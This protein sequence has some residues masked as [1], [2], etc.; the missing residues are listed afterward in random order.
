MFA[1]QSPIL[2][3]ASALTAQM[4]LKAAENRIRDLFK[5]GSQIWQAHAFNGCSNL[6][7]YPVPEASDE[8]DLFADLKGDFLSVAEF[9]P[10]KLAIAIHD[11]YDAGPSLEKLSQSIIVNQEFEIS[12][13]YLRGGKRSE[14]APQLMRIAENLK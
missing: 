6:C 13:Q 8:A 5:F 2:E 10:P 3:D 11:F 7:D 9:S 12:G 1:E 4:G 14:L